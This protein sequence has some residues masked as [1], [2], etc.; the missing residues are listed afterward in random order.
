MSPDNP[1]SRG[2]HLYL[3]SD[4]SPI[5]M[6]GDKEPQKHGYH[7]LIW[8]GPRMSDIQDCEEGLFSGSITLYGSGNSDDK[9]RILFHDCNRTVF[10]RSDMALCNMMGSNYE[11]GSHKGMENRDTLR[12]KTIIDSLND[13]E[14]KKGNLSPDFRK[15]INEERLPVNP[16]NRFN[17]SFVSSC[18][19]YNG[20]GERCRINHNDVTPMQD[21]FILVEQIKI[22]G[23]A[24]AC[25][26]IGEAKAKE[27]DSGR[28][29][30]SIGEI[31]NDGNT[32][33]YDGIWFMSYNPN[34]VGRMGNEDQFVSLAILLLCIMG[35]Q[36][37]E[38]WGEEDRW[39]RTVKS[40]NKENRSDPLLREI[41]HELDLAIHDNKEKWSQIFS[42]Y[43][44]LK[45][46]HIDE[47]W[48]LY[49]YLSI[50]C[51]GAESYSVG[52]IPE[53]IKKHIERGSA[54][55]PS[56]D[57]DILLTLDEVNRETKSG[58]MEFTIARAVNTVTAAVLTHMICLNKNAEL[59]KSLDTKNEFR[60]LCYKHDVPATES[61]VLENETVENLSVSTFKGYVGGKKYVV[62][63]LHSS[64]GFG[65]YLFEDPTPSRELRDDPG[66]SV[67]EIQ[68]TND[69][70][71]T[72]L[73]DADCDSLVISKYRDPNISVNVHAIITADDIYISPCSLQII[74]VTDHRLIYSGADFEAFRRYEQDEPHKVKELYEYTSWLCGTLKGRGYRGIIGFDV[75]LSDKTEFVEANNRFQA[76][77]VL[78]NKALAEYGHTKTNRRIQYRYDGKTLIRGV[79]L[80]SMQMQN[81]IAFYEEDLPLFRGE[82]SENSNLKKRCD[83]AKSMIREVCNEFYGIDLDQRKED[84]SHIP[85]LKSEFRNLDIPYSFYIYYY[86]WER[87][88]HPDI[89][90]H[91]YI[92]DRIVEISGELRES[93]AQRLDECEL[94]AADK[95]NRQILDYTNVLGS[96][97][98]LGEQ[99]VIVDRKSTAGFALIEKVERIRKQHVSPELDCLCSRLERIVSGDEII[100][101]R[102]LT[103]V[104]DSVNSP[105]DQWYDALNR[106]IALTKMYGRKLGEAFDSKSE[107]DP[108]EISKGKGDD[109]SSLGPGSKM[110]IVEKT[111]HTL[112]S[113]L[114]NLRLKSNPFDI[115]DRLQMLTSGILESLGIAETDSEEGLS[116]SISRLRICYDDEISGLAK[117]LSGYESSRDQ[118]PS[119]GKEE[120]RIREMECTL[121]EHIDRLHRIRASM[122]YL[123]QQRI[124]LSQIE[125][126]KSKK[127]ATKDDIITAAFGRLRSVRMPGIKNDGSD[128]MT[129]ANTL[130]SDVYKKLTEDC[131]EDNSEC[132]IFERDGWDSNGED[133]ISVENGAYMFK[134]LI[135]GNI[136]SAIFGRSVVHPN[137]VA[138]SESWID[139]ILDKRRDVVALK[140]A[141]INN[142]IRISERAEEA[143]GDEKIR[144]GVNYSVD[145]LVSC[146]PFRY[147][148]ATYTT[149]PI[150]CA[151]G[152]A[153]SK[154]SPFVLDHDGN[155]FYFTFYDK[156][157]EGKNGKVT[158]RYFKPCKYTTDITFVATDRVRFQHH[159]R[160]DF[161]ATGKGCKFCEF[162]AKDTSVHKKPRF[163]ETDIIRDVT[164]VMGA[165][166][167]YSEFLSLSTD[168]SG[169]DEDAVYF[170]HVLIGG[171]TYLASPYDVKKRIL[172]IC[173]SINS[174]AG[175]DKLPIYLMCIPPNRLSDMDEYKDA[176]V[177]EVAFNIEI[178]SQ[179]LAMKY[180][181]GKNRTTL[182]RYISALR[183]ATRVWKKP[184]SVRSSLI[185]GLEHPDR[186][187][188]GVKILSSLG[189]SPILS[190]F[191][192][193]PGTELG[194]VMPL[195]SE[196]LYN[197]FLA[198]YQQCKDV[199]V[200]LGP[201]CI[202][203]QNNTVTLPPELVERSI[204]M[205][206]DMDGRGE[207]P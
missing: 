160:C 92:R 104:C 191:R 72:K 80:P 31:F 9:N 181:P 39:L 40:K 111:N 130:L 135:H 79:R 159:D 15:I 158:V 134:A 198:A 48:V 23:A 118:D 69:L 60:K 10:D 8:T 13:M 164:T 175:A 174:A 128:S 32:E 143:M 186:T 33:Y 167:P 156:D 151:L 103:A 35:G 129:Y 162:T 107:E 138:P 165:R 42:L 105:N 122:D 133:P 36:D 206:K 41:S 16:D 45:D 34:F 132:E 100:L 184:G 30:P 117:Y 180:M 97:G 116:A 93:M 56:D 161:A 87:T 187:L 154:Y 44:E 28:D 54:G 25:Q 64:G 46:S 85:L 155:V 148:G 185:I 37:Q 81:L 68:A 136:S 63:K 152:N 52:E 4:L 109:T 172:D 75:L 61:I 146:D 123:V 90:H 76:S 168:G 115:A 149:L 53:D 124:C 96:V 89:V 192:P 73:E 65:T 178:Y 190:I 142:G 150:N 29:P 17:L 177:T 2:N 14:V 3:I 119:K 70:I 38:K 58:K 82:K 193:V 21:L 47:L 26:R 182:V 157:I 127:D 194:F 86:P 22:L 201:S 176:G 11:G 108:V 55:I 51:C 188:E 170:D 19:N 27:K 153:I 114:I 67:K 5:R 200:R 98:K 95:V 204:S 50:L 196:E 139:R 147:N 169:A 195:S 78:I 83:N 126:V 20:G 199:D 131:V 99:F 137:L 202:H 91:K 205:Y 179:D 203:C 145:L 59:M 88:K 183:Y 106:F 1:T 49:S 171:G 43:K 94:C 66:V 189:V 6:K 102:N 62:Q 57:I 207:T 125:S 112:L 18:Y 113:E 166:R 12:A 84:E 7:R 140:I 197:L 163:D 24:K 77:T 71:R 121:K 110:N 74:T 141:L 101:L 144:S 173:D 120:G